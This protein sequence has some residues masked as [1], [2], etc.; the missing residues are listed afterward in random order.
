MHARGGMQTRD[1]ATE[2]VN[3]IENPHIAKELYVPSTKSSTIGSVSRVL[4]E[5]VNQ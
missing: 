5:K 4:L 1:I 3:I 2:V